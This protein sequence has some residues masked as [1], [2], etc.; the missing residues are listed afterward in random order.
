MST[1][2]KMQKRDNRRSPIIRKGQSRSEQDFLK[3]V[4]SDLVWI[5]RTTELKINRLQRRISMIES[6]QQID[7]KSLSAEQ[8][9]FLQPSYMDRLNKKLAE[10]KRCKEKFRQISSEDLERMIGEKF[11]RERQSPI[12]PR[13]FAHEIAESIV[14]S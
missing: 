2:V 6:L 13:K 12:D 3:I 11:L 14:N 5:A 9:N 1:V 8:K 4:E 10:A 7:Q